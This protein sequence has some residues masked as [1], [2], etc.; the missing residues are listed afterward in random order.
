[1]K[2]TSNSFSKPSITTSSLVIELAAVVY[3]LAALYSQKG[4]VAVNVAV[5]GLNKR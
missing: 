3:N 5:D 4:Y 2:W 1:M